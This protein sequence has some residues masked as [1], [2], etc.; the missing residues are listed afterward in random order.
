MLIKLQFVLVPN[1]NQGPGANRTHD[2][3]YDVANTRGISDKIVLAHVKA[4]E[5]SHAPSPMP[6]ICSRVNL[7]TP[8]KVYIFMS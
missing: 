3:A 5:P 6:K 4:K 7:F 1:F 2:V 8:A